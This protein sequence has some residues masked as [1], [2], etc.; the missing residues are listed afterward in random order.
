MSPPS[1]GGQAR[2]NGLLLRLLVW[3]TP[4][5]RRYLRDASLRVTRQA[6]G[7]VVW[8]SVVSL[9]G[10]V[11]AI[12]IKSKYPQNVGEALIKVVENLQ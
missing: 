6:D 5:Q 7:W 4:R 3:V 9:S 1:A 11:Y 8:G 2:V 12:D 10:T